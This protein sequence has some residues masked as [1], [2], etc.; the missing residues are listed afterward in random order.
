MKIKRWTEDEVKFLTENHHLGSKFCAK[1]LKK[2]VYAIVSKKDSLKLRLTEEQL[3]ILKQSSKVKKVNPDQ[4]FNIQTPELAYFLGYFWADGSILSGDYLISLIICSSDAEVLKE[5]FYKIGEWPTASYTRKRNGKD[6]HSTSFRVG[7]KVI[8]TFLKDHDY[9]I[10]SGASA[11]KILS[12]IPDHLKH[13]WWRG[14]F[15]GDGYWSPDGLLASFTSGTYQDWSFAEKLCN[16]LGVSFDIFRKRYSKDGK[17]VGNSAIIMKKAPNLIKFGQYIYQNYENDKIGLYRKYKNYLLS[18]KKD[19]Y[20]NYKPIDI[21]FDK[22][23]INDNIDYRV[24]KIIELIKLNNY[25][26]S[27]RNLI[28]YFNVSPGRILSAQREL[29]KNKLVK[30]VNTECGDVFVYTDE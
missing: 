19:E 8:W 26:I 21:E 3:S 24:S 2:S 7:N 10:K 23:L 20:L 15:D 29:R 1:H 14:Y 11:D 30:S 28:K 25:K 9:H 4:F 22:Q 12:K 27:R 18:I 6:F 5:I 13:Y 16:D 17:I